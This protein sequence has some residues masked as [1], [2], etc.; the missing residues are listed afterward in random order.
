MRIDLGYGEGV[1]SM[2]VQGQAIHVMMPKASESRLSIRPE[3]I[4]SFEMLQKVDSTKRSISRAKNISIAADFQRGLGQT[5]ILLAE[6]L[7]YFQTLSILERVTI[8]TRTPDAI[9]TSVKKP[10]GVKT[11]ISNPS[12]EKAMQ[13]IGETP[14]N[15]TPV[16]APSGFIEADFK[17]A[18][19]TIRADPIYGATGGPVSLLY[20]A[21]GN[22][23]TL[24]NEKLGATKFSQAF[25]RNCPA[26][27]DAHEV[28]ALLDVDCAL[29]TVTDYQGHLHTLLSGHVAKEWE[30]GLESLHDLA[31]IQMKQK[32]DVAVVS[33]GGSP[34]DFTLA[35]AVQALMA[36]HLA[37]VHGGVILLVAECRDGPGPKG[38]V[39]GVSEFETED[40]IKAAVESS[41]RRGMGHARLIHRVLAS[42]RVV[43]CSR[44]RRSLVEERLRCNAVRDPEEGIELAKTMIASR[45]SFAVIPFGADS[46]PETPP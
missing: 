34:H 3:V 19:G 18:L 22:R 7:D 42:R 35:D 10:S 14:S 43:L 4:R 23:T 38:L 27:L 44:L 15:A 30:R 29:N 36:G 26:A 8:F 40:S 12:G 46:L 28:S 16:H 9:L 45:P 24:R 39:E 37:T 1:L 41:F 21:C 5:E 25:D 33:P 11:N 17:M 31:A 32:A 2:D 13:L 20:S 6:V